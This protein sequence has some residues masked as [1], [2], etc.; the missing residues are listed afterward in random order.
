MRDVDVAVTE[1]SLFACIMEL[2][3]HP[4]GVFCEIIRYI[5]AVVA[6]C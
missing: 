1:V 2:A 3:E 6:L 5:Y 4:S